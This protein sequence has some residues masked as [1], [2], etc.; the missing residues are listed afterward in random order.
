VTAAR[1]GTDAVLAVSD[2]GVGLER[3][4]LARVFD[5]FYQATGK[6]QRKG[7]LGIGLTLVRRLV[8]LHGGSVSVHSDGPGR[9]ARFVVR[10]PALDAPRG[11]LAIV[12]HTASCRATRSVLVVEDNEDARDSLRKLLALD[13]HIVY[14][15]A[16]GRAGVETALAKTPDV[17]VLD[18]GLPQL[19]G[20]EVARILRTRLGARVKLIA[21]T[22]YGQPEDARRAREAG[23]DLHMTKPADLDKLRAALGGIRKEIT[24]KDARG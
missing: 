5:L 2:T 14:E 3:D 7:G 18:I 21:L 12:P 4:E 16:D 6:A 22:G 13:G 24:A 23:F 9:G 10:L 19:D 20:Y 1:E 15:A 11:E 17:V 8:E